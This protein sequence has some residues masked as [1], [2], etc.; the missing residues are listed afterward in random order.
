[1][2]NGKYPH[3]IR[4]APW[5][6][7]EA[8]ALMRYDNRTLSNLAEKAIHD[9]FTKLPQKIREELMKSANEGDGDCEEC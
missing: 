5:A 7:A 4:L 8:D 1:M 2:V 6:E 9:K 3:K